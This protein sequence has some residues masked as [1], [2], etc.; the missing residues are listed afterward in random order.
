MSSLARPPA[1][2]DVPQQLTDQLLQ[3][4]N[5][6]EQENRRLLKENNE[7]MEQQLNYDAVIQ[8]GREEVARL[9]EQ[10]EGFREENKQL[11]GQVSSLVEQVA[12]AENQIASLN[13]II[14]GDV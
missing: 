9:V 3:R 13:A 5:Q 8:I 12:D 11:K 14:K 10:N 6:L 1:Y 7:L 4:I 2:N